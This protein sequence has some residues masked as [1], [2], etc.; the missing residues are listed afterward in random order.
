MDDLKERVEQF[1]ALELPGQP[2]CMHMGTSYL[3]QDL[4]K[5]IAKLEALLEVYDNDHGRHCIDHEPGYCR[6]ADAEARLKKVHNDA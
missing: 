6:I 2:R 3:V 5:R 4:V 1:R